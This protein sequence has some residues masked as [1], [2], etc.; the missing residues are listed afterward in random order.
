ML[1]D[2]MRYCCVCRRERPWLVGGYANHP[3]R[4]RRGNQQDFCAAV[5]RGGAECARPPL[6]LGAL[7]LGERI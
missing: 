2:M 4:H 6:G 7:S 1:K 5:A 3:R